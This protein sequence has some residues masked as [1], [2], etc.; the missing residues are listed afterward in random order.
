MGLE[1]VGEALVN[2]GLPVHIL[3]LSFKTDLEGS[4]DREITAHDPSVIGLTVRN[5]DDCSFASR[6]SFLP[7]ICELVDGVRRR[8]DAFLLL[9]GAGFSADFMHIV[10]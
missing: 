1:Y 7:W 3:D 8:T 2:A 6:R 9:G 10:D 4:L 5:T